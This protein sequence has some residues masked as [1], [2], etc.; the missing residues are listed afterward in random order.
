MQD[1][2]DGK[3]DRNQNDGDVQFLNKQFSKF[4]DLKEKIDLKAKTRI[5]KAVSMSI[6]N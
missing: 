5:Y 3:Y 1:L 4:K 6:P 2:E